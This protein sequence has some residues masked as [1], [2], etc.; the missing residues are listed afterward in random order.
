MY[1]LSCKHGVWLLYLGCR[2]DEDLV[3][4]LRKRCYDLAGTAGTAVYWN[5]TRLPVRNF[6]D[7]VDL[8][9]GESPK[10]K[11][12]KRKDNGKTLRK[13]KGSDDDGD[14]SGDSE[15]EEDVDNPPD[16][17]K[18][19]EGEQEKQRVKIHEKMH[20]WEVVISQS[21]RPLY[22]MYFVHS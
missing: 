11:G 22:V 14:D 2:L 5:G 12:G 17:D 8:Y 1:I 10:R 19:N 13:K 16:A 4:L 3:S 9:L 18:E 6:V 20:R 21:G 15:V 7:Y